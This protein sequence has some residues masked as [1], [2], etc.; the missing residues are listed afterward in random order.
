MTTSLSEIRPAH[1]A[2]TAWIDAR[3][4][5]A[6]ALLPCARNMNGSSYVDHASRTRAVPGHPSRA[7]VPEHARTAR[8]AS[9]RQQVS[10]H[11]FDLLGD[12]IGAHHHRLTAASRT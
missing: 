6:D 5:Y 10:R 3:R 9:R 12:W 4:C 7:G 1:P 11:L 2:L 8:A